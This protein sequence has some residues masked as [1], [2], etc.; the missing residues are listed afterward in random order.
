MALLCNNVSHWLCAILESALP[1]PKL[2]II[3]SLICG[4]LLS[5][6]CRHVDGSSGN[7]SFLF[8]ILTGPPVV[9]SIIPG[10]LF[11]KQKLGLVQLWNE[12]ELGH[13]HKRIIDTGV[14]GCLC[15]T[16]F[17]DDVV[18]WKHFPHHWPFVRGI[19]QWPVDSPH[20]GQWCGAL[21]FSLI[22]AWT[23]GCAKNQDA[24]DLR[25]HRAHYDVMVM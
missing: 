12:N 14:R 11:L 10:K 20:K 9:G 23:N 3:H 13:C 4:T 7:S 1:W 2:L 5:S 22:C 24:S 6:R 18:K 8:T 25:C 19:Q 17:H 21:K 15:V 16:A